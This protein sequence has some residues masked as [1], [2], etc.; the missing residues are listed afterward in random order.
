[1]HLSM[2]SGEIM[3]IFRVSDYARKK[4]TIHKT[5]LPTELKTKKHKC[6]QCSRD[7]AILLKISAKETRWLCPIHIQ[8]YQNQ[9][10]IEKPSFVRASKL[11]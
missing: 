7:N 5:R 3:S 2:P 10:K 9:G 11:G 1:M 8:K 6:S 4:E